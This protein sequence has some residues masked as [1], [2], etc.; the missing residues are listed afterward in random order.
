MTLLSA[1]SP[2]DAELVVRLPFRAG[3]HI[4]YV[5]DEG[6]ENDDR[7]EMRALEAGI[8]EVAAHQNSELIRYIAQRILERKPEWDTWTEGVFDLS[9]ECKR[10]AS[11][12][13]H[14]FSE[15]DVDSYKKMVMSVARAVAQAYGEFGMDEAEEPGFFSGLMKKIVGGL[16]RDSDADQPMNVSAAEDS[17]LE[18]LKEALDI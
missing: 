4:S 9:G 13:E 15:D 8:H 5:E 6:G 1:L 3:V 11:I 10:A 16:S 12:V 2:E 7:L 18:V 17:A 14:H